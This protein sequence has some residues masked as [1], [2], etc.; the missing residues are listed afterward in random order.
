MAL[1]C[2]YCN[3][4]YAIHDKYCPMQSHLGAEAKENMRN[5]YF[6]GI[7]KPWMLQWFDN[8][9]EYM[10]LRI[11][12]NL[13]GSF[14]LGRSR[15]V[16]GERVLEIETREPVFNTHQSSQV[17]NMFTEHFVNVITSPNEPRSFVE[18]KKFAD[19]LARWFN[20]FD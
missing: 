8:Y 19:E 1:H 14:D 15:S 3:G 12:E 18:L 9:D 4:L 16:R 5:A 10:K 11:P 6:L 7:I 20:R 2:S 17:V 13:W